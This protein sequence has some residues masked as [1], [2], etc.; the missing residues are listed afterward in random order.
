M[1]NILIVDDSIIMRRN[2]KTIFTKAG[3][4][5]I[6]E[7]SNGQQALQLYEKFLPDVVTM[8]IT[9]PNVNGIEAV[10]L[11]ISKYPDAKIIIISGLDQKNVVYSALEYGAKHYIIKPI[12]EKKV[13]DILDAVLNNHNSTTITDIN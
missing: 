10:K 8:D 1:A 9:M 4:N 5:V 11:I 13:L 2:L 3:H 6:A 7:A 12:S